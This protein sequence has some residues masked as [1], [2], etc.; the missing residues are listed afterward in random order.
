MNQKRQPKGTDNGGQFAPDANSESTVV[1]D[2]GVTSAQRD[3]S[4][5]EKSDDYLEQF[6]EDANSNFDSWLDKRA[7]EGDDWNEWSMADALSFMEAFESTIHA[8]KAGLLDDV[9]RAE[10]RKSATS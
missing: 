4:A 7:D 6:A 3:E 2:D 9:R 5:R 8:R 10:L 1:L